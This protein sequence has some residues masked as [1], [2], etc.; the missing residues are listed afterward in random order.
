MIEEIEIFKK[1]EEII[2]DL[3]KEEIINDFRIEMNN[4]ILIIIMIEML[5]IREITMNDFKSIFNKLID[6]EEALIIKEIEMN[7][8]V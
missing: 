7:Q 6:K 3:M 4:Q 1:E 2:I 8:M 5:D